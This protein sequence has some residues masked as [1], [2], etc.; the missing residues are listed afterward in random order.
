MFAEF[1]LI[2]GGIALF[3]A[4]SSQRMSIS[5]CGKRPCDWM[6]LWKSFLFC[7]RHWIRF[8]L[9]ISAALV[10]AS[11][12]RVIIDERTGVALVIAAIVGQFV[13]VLALFNKFAAHDG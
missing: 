3:D 10:L 9:T 6:A 1:L 8:V 11:I 5:E 7:R 2:L 4:L 12:G 13:A